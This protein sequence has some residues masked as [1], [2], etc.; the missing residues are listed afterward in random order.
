MND[1][2]PMQMHDGLN[3]KSHKVSSFLFPKSLLLLDILE[4]ILPEDV[5]AHNIDGRLRVDG[6]LLSGELGGL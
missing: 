6:L 3:N 4:Q 2:D 1:L 5:L